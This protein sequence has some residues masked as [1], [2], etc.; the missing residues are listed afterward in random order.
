MDMKI[1]QKFFNR[2]LLWPSLLA[3]V[4]LIA[5]W[6][7]PATTAPLLF[8]KSAGQA[9]TQIFNSPDE[10][11]NFYFS[12]NL[13][14]NNSLSISEPLNNELGN[15]V[16][17]RSIAASNG[18]LRPLSFIGLPVIYGVLA[19][20]FT[21]KTIPFF[22]GFIAALSG[23]VFYWLL[24]RAFSQKWAWFG[25]L[26]LY[27][28]PAY[29]Y[30]TARGMFHNVLFVDLL[31]VSL[32]IGGIT[33]ALLMFG[34]LLVRTFE[35]VWVWPIF[36]WI[37]NRRFKITAVAVVAVNAIILFFMR[38]GY[39]ANL[40]P[41]GFLFERVVRNIWHIHLLT[42][43][44][45]TLPAV[46]GAIIW[47]LMKRS[48]MYLGLGIF[49]TV[50]LLVYYGT[51]AIADNPSGQLTIVSSLFR[52]WLPIFIWEIPFIILLIETLVEFMWRRKLWQMV[53]PII[54]LG[55]IIFNSV[56]FVWS[57]DDGL[58]N[59][60]AN[61]K[62]IAIIKEQVLDIVPAEAVIIADRGT[63]KIFFP[64]RRVIYD[65]R[66]QYNWPQ[67]EKL[68]SLVPAYY[69]GIGLNHTDPIINR[70]K[71]KGILLER[72]AIFD[73]EALYKLKIK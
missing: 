16:Y 42:M 20:I 17:P 37:G 24:R 21:V 69:Y 6:W 59:T 23:L 45:W 22:T 2:E 26:L 47:F 11:A 28:N 33:G 73:K 31:L 58:I 48:R 50:W 62:R 66:D 13:A 40:L 1:Y 3:L 30:Y 19:K 49:G 14:V 7:L 55:I 46:A 54:I 18:M 61:L 68:V 71:E 44:W 38:P 43:W 51:F 72:I 63:D 64:D 10:M 70:L 29:F 12:K 5:V 53:L 39:P 65:L 67:Y 25:T 41:F 60:R 56:C 4:F 32:L 35:G 57:G 52:Y 9:T 34:A 15:R 36:T 8:G 27:I